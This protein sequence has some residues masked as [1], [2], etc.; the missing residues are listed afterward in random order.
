MNNTKRVRLACY[1]TNVLMA[2]VG[3][4]SP[5]LFLTFKTVYNVSYALLGALVL[6]NFITQLTVDLIFSFFSHKINMAKAVKITP[7]IGFIGL[8]VYSLGPLFHSSGAFLWII[9][10]T[11]IFSASSGFAEVLI[12]PVIAAL[13]SETPERDMSKLHSIYA[14]GSVGVVLLGTLFLLA[15][16]AERWYLLGLIFSIIP[17][18]GSVLFFKAEIPKME[19]PEKISGT[20][21]LIKKPQLWICFAAM[22]LGGASEVSMAQWSSGYIE[23]ALGISKIYGDIFGVAL[24]SGMLALGRT[25]YAKHGKS[26]EKVLLLGAVGAAAC[27]IIATVTSIS[28]VGLLACGITG[29]CVS[30][31]WPGTLVVSSKRITEGGV[32]VYAMMAAGG[33]MGAAIA[34]QLIGIACDVAEQ[35]GFALSLAESLGISVEG[36]AMKI[37]L[38]IGSLFP[39]L[40]IAAYIYIFK[41]RHIFDK[42]GI[43]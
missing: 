14:W 28:V 11:V 38:A 6:I 22:F 26:I 9:L 24:F 17:I 18:I 31:L 36:A 21:E 7:V 16:G 5:I 32:F 15:F 37:G 12:S 25:L 1:S 40:A 8:L 41:S 30:M 23:T 27:Y 19:T 20:L 42:P 3:N 2:V 39:I 43:E 34:P 10:G 4:L 33:D 35:S 29:I 13:P